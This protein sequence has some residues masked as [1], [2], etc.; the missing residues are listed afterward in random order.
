MK[1][2]GKNSLS[3]GVKVCLNCF[4]NYYQ[5]QYYR[6]TKKHNIIFIHGNCNTSSNSGL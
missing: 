1:I 5:G 2:L 6:R 4:F 3:A